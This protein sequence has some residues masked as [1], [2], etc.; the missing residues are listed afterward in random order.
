MLKANLLIKVRTRSATPH[1]NAEKEAD[2]YVFWRPMP[3]CVNNK[4]GRASYTDSVYLVYVCIHIR[5]LLFSNMEIFVQFPFFLL[6]AAQGGGEGIWMFYYINAPLGTYEQ[7]SL[8]QVLHFVIN[9]AAGPKNA[10]K[11]KRFLGCGNS[12]T[13]ME[14]NKLDKIREFLL[15]LL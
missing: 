5:P 13:C 4:R 2:K 9:N 8:S 15:I 1:L 11:I 6:A 14:K 10:R 7:R 3:T 12:L